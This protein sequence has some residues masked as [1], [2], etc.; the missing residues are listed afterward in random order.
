[1][2]NGTERLYRLM[3][4]LIRASNRK[5]DYRLAIERTHEV[6]WV[7]SLSQPIQ[8]RTSRFYGSPK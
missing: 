2:P 4:P 8:K 1:M 5:P 3:Q 6:Q 7:F